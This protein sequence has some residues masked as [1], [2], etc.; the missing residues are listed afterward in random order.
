M[1]RR[2]YLVGQRVNT[3]TIVSRIKPRAIEAICDCGRK[4]V[5]SSRNFKRDSICQCSP[6]YRQK[7]KFIR[8]GMSK[9]REYRSWMAMKTRCTNPLSAGYCDYGGRGISVC[10]EW[11]DSFDAFY[12]DMGARPPGTSLDRI[13]VNAGYSKENCRWATQSQQ[14]ENRRDSFFIKIQDEK[15]SA[16]ALAA[17]LGVLRYVVYDRATRGLT[18]LEIISTRVRKKG[19]KLKRKAKPGGR[20]YQ[21]ADDSEHISST[22]TRLQ[23]QKIQALQNNDSKTASLIQKIIDLLNT[24]K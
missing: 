19:V 24:R 17:I 10:N 3:F 22:L 16:R 4:I 9:C 6:L 18:P 8:H 12:R 2:A 14:N 11:L 13:D 21:R 15:V 5:L 1:K 23:A 7:K 20:G